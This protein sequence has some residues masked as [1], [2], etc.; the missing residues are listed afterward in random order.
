MSSAEHLQKVEQRIRK[1]ESFLENA[2]GDTFSRFALALEYLKA[3]RA[4]EA[5]MIFVDI[6][7]NQP[8]YS[9]VYYHLGKLYEEKGKYDEAFATYSSGIEVCQRQQELHALKELQEAQMM[10]RQALDD[11]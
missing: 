7:E 6:A 10:L 9:G 4:E 8:D 5:E 3:E 11:D 1:L 2:P